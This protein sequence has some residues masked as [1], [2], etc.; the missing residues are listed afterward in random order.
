MRYLFVN[1]G[2]GTISRRRLRVFSAHILLF[3]F[4]RP[5]WPC[6]QPT[7][8]YPPNHSTS[9][10]CSSHRPNTSIPVHSR[11]SWFKFHDIPLPT[12]APAYIDSEPTAYGVWPIT[13][14]FE[15]SLIMKFSAGWPNPHDIN[16]HIKLNWGLSAEPMVSLIGPRHVLILPASYQD[17]VLVRWE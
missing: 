6:R 9:L 15:N 11:P 1:M 3:N 4:F 14:Q 7:S 13:K 12:R 17:M 10:L 2:S 8:G 16:L 5:L